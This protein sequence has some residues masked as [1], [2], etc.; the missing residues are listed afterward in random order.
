MIPAPPRTTGVVKVW[1]DERG[2]GFAAPAQGGPD[3][4]VHVK[5]LSR[6]S[7]KPQ[8]G[9]VLSFEIELGPQGKPRARNVVSARVVEPVAPRPPVRSPRS[10]PLGFLAIAGFIGV[11]LMIDLVR[12]I[13]YW[14]AVLYLALSV[15]T[16][17][18][19]AL[20]KSASRAGGWRLS[21]SSLL[22]LGLIGGWPG[23]IVAQ[24]VFRHKTVKRSFRLVFWLTVVLNVACFVLL[25]WFLGPVD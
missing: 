5:S 18:A 22:S 12:P 15:G 19:Y 2:F 23:A 4:F 3:V 9:D 11:Y 14:V 16:F 6:E 24:Q 10:G 8:V 20:D 25:T 13:P 1:N 17:V 7:A 21:E